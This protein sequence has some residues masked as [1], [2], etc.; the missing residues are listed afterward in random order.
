MI[1][2]F[3]EQRQG[4]V[5]ADELLKAIKEDL[6]V[7]GINEGQVRFTSLSFYFRLIKWSQISI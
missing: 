3:L 6:H 7:G 1:L 5:L 2:F 4:F